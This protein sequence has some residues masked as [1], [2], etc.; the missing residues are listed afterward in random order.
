MILYQSRL[1]ILLYTWRCANHAIYGRFNPVQ[2]AE[3]AYHNLRTYKAS[4]YWR[5]QECAF[6]NN[7]ITW[8]TSSDFV[9]PTVKNNC[10]KWRIELHLLSFITFL[11]AI[12][13]GGK[14]YL[15][16]DT[17]ILWC[18]WSCL[19]WSSVLVYAGFWWEHSCLTSLSKD[20][21]LDPSNVWPSQGSSSAECNY[22][23]VS[24]T[25]SKE[26]IKSLLIRC[27]HGQTALLYSVG[28]MAILGYSKHTWGIVLP[29]LW[30]YLHQTNGTM[31][32]VR[33]NPADCASRGLYPSEFLDHTLWWN[34]PE[35]LKLPSSEWPKS[36]DCSLTLGV[37][38]E[39]KQV[40]LH[41]AVIQRDPVI[42]QDR[43]S[44]FT[45]LTRVTAWIL[46][47]IHNSHVP[48]EQNVSPTLTV[49]ELIAAKHYWVRFSQADHFVDDIMALQ[50]RKELSLSSPLTP[51]H[52]FLDQKCSTCWW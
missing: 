20:E 45:I 28:W 1:V 6:D 16:R 51:L 49:Q 37:Q 11:D 2:P 52:P 47:F 40:S 21:G 48:N 50:D 18:L 17:W 14:N 27:M 32:T 15:H 23:L 4:T 39:K 5:H 9:P 30:N 25:T 12:S 42:P 3:S 33:T 35:W 26:S 44:L 24:S 19:H 43:F 36:P 7:S 8:P 29:A 10:L 38:S 13:K 46:Q 34:G 22:L 31:L 41:S